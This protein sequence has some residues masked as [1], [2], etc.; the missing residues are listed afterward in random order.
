MKP[1]DWFVLRTDD[2]DWQIYMI[3]YWKSLIHKN[4][5]HQNVLHKIWH[6][7]HQRT[8]ILVKKICMAT[9]M[10]MGCRY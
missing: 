1:F 9:C 8:L 7:Q 6:Q 4:L 2:F 5:L 3:I 10:N